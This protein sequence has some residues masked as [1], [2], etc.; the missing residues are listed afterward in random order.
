MQPTYV[1]IKPKE[2]R[3]GLMHHDSDTQATYQN[4]HVGMGAASSPMVSDSSSYLSASPPRVSGP[5]MAFYAQLDFSRPA[6]SNPKGKGGDGHERKR[7]SEDGEI[8]MTL[9]LSGVAPPPNKTP[10]P[11]ETSRT[12]HSPPPTQIQL[13]KAQQSSTEV[14][15][16][17]AAAVIQNRDDGLT[18]NYSTLNFDAMRALQL[19]RDK[20][21][22]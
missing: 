20:R 2:P 17:G 13:P 21:K 7:S 8:Y 15:R 11:M 18:V 14:S 10:E 6:T 1:N 4:L 3:L 5:K 19:T 12:R 16:P 9:N 22:T